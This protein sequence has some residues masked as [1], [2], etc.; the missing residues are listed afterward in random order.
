MIPSLCSLFNL[1]SLKAAWE[2]VYSSNNLQSVFLG[3]SLKQKPQKPPGEL[4]LTVYFPNQN[5]QDKSDA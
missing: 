1:P 3:L 5:L 4:I 2:G